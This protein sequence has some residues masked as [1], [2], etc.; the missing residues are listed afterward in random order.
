MQKFKP[1]ITDQLF[2]LPPNIEDFVPQD[3]LAR[4]VNDVVETIDVSSIENKYSLLGQKSYHPHLLLKLLFYGYSTGV[5]SGRKIAMAC[6]Q[7][8]AFMYLAWMYRPD[9]RT[10]NDFRKDNLDFIHQC[11]SHIVQVCK[12]LGMA[13]AGTLILDGTKLRANA[14]GSHSKTKEQYEQWLVRIEAD[15]TGILN[16]AERNDAA[17]DKLYGHKRGDELPKELQSKQ[18]LKEKIKEALEKIKDDKQR[19]N[20]TDNDAKYIMGKTGI[21][22]N[23]NCQAA[24]TEDGIIV[25]AYTSNNPSDRSETI[26]S[27]EIA[28]QTSAEKYHTIIADSGYA[29]YNHFDTLHSSEKIIYMPDQ[30]MLTE[31]EDEK[32]PH[33]RNHFIY[34]KESNTFTCPEQKVLVYSRKSSCIKRNQQSDIY[35]CKA[36]PAC[37][38]QQVCTKGKYWQ[39]NVEKREW[40]RNQIR[41]RLNSTEGKKIYKKRMLIE[42]IFGIIKHN[43]N[44]IRLQLR[45]MEKTTAEWRLICIGYNI[46]RLHK[47]KLS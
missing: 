23:Y 39:I 1:V 27:I 41:E 43:L 42:S 13:R 17:E 34:D 19:I 21:D 46:K 29:S 38:K 14:S 10:I 36:C 15:I 2:L 11:F 24:I 31:T 33:H 3:H 37:D 12:Q 5:R 7:D 25:G 20:L 35:V 6:Q 18:K 32:N 30:A 16:E 45:G 4:V 44:Y 28:E 8:T 22:T 40:L 26:R 47:M 9:F